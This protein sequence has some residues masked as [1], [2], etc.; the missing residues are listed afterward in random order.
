LNGIYIVAM[1]KELARGILGEGGCYTRDGRRYRGSVSGD[2]SIGRLIEGRAQQH[3]LAERLL[4][5]SCGGPCGMNQYGL[6]RKL[7]RG[8]AY[9][10]DLLRN[11]MRII[12]SHDGILLKPHRM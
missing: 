4:Q 5:G 7:E 6:L 9:M 3:H 10:K 8:F 1:K 2:M 12:G 11:E